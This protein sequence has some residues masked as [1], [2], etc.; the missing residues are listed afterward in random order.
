MK[1]LSNILTQIENV[2]NQKVNEILASAQ[3]SADEI[4]AKAKA[5]AEKEAE[6]DHVSV[7]GGYLG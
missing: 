6:K 1:G 2:A 7:S 5:K 4:I 3:N